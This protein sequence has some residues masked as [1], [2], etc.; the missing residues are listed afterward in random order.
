MPI[1]ALKHVHDSYILICS[2]LS[3]SFVAINV[4]LNRTNYEWLIYMS[5]IWPLGLK[6]YVNSKFTVCIYSHIVI[7]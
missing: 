4:T 7:L 1:D 5:V 3:H 6:V 2:I